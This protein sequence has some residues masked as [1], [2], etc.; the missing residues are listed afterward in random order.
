VVLFRNTSPALAAVMDWRDRLAPGTPDRTPDG[1]VLDDQQTLTLTLNLESTPFQ[2]GDTAEWDGTGTLLTFKR[3]TVTMP[4]PPLVVAGGHVAFE[5]R[6]PE[7][8]NRQPFAVH[9]TFQAFQGN[10][11]K[12][13]RFEE[14]LLWLL[15]PPEYFTGKFLTYDNMVEVWIS[16]VADV[17][18]RLTGRDMVLFHKHVLAAAFQLQ[19]RWA[20]E[21]VAEKT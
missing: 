10:L 7:L 11:G 13:A 1:W 3:Q 19:V 2:S 4:L 12:K 8:L 15:H 5:Q 17:W 20:A 16:H 14:N 21:R 9:A 18:K 6:L